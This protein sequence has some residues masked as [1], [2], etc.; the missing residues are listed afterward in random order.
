MDLTFSRFIPYKSVRFQYPD[1][2]DALR[3][4]MGTGIVG[5]GRP[6]SQVTRTCLLSERTSRA[7]S[8]RTDMAN[9]PLR[10]CGNSFCRELTS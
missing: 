1:S 8:L 3:Q 5:T 10:C 9:D 6:D 7:K 4:R 2:A